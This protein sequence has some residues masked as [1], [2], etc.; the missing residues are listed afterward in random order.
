MKNIFPSIFKWFIVIAGIAITNNLLGQSQQFNTLSLK[1]GLSQGTANAIAQDL[2]GFMWMGTSD[3]LNRFDGYEFNVLRYDAQDTTSI[4]NNSITALTVGRNGDVWA[5]AEMGLNRVNPITLQANHYYHKVEN[6]KSLSSNKITA[7]AEDDLGRLWVGTDNGLNRLDNWDKNHFFRYSIESQDSVSL[8]NNKINDIFLDSKGNIW[9]ATEGG[10]NKYIVDED[11][12]K[13][14]RL[15]YNDD[16]SLSDNRVTSICEDPHGNLWVGTKNGLNK[17]NPELEV[18]S[19]YF[20]D[21]PR[22]NLLPSN[23]INDVIYDKEG[24]MWV[25]TP[26]G[27]SKV[28]KEMGK[29]TLYYTHPGKTNTLPND[30]ILCLFPGQNGM[31]WIGTRAAGVVTLDLKAPRFFSIV[32]S[33]QEGYTPEENQVYSFFEQDT[34]HIWLGTGRGVAIY[35][36]YSDKTFF[37]AKQGKKA[38]SKITYPVLSFAQTD[39]GIK[40]I[41]TDGQGLIAYNAKNDSLTYYQTNADDEF[42][43]SSNRINAIKVTADNNLWVA[44]SGGGLCFLDR[45]TNKFKIYRY[46]GRNS[47]T[48]QDNNIKTIALDKN[49]DVWFGTGNLGLYYLNVEHDEIKHYPAGDPNTGGLPS[50]GINDLFINSTNEL[51]IATAGGGLSKY[52]P[53]KDGFKTYT[54]LDGLI[55]NVVL[56]VNSDNK[57]NLWLSTNG[58]I[59]TFN[60]LTETFRNYNEQEV[61]GQNTFYARSSISTSTGLFVFGGANGFDYINANGIQENFLLPPLI[62]TSFQLINKRESH[63]N[64]NLHIDTNEEIILDF[65]HSGFAIEFAALNF[66]QSQ[67]NQYAYRLKGLFDQWRYIGTRNFATFSNL[68]PG[69]YSFEVIGSNNDGYWNDS[70]ATLKVIVQ[71]AYWQTSWFRILVLVAILGVLYLYYKFKLSSEKERNQRLEHAV[72]SRTAEIAKERDTNAILLKEVHHRVKNNLQI[73]ISLLNLQSRF[74]SDSK[75]MDVFSEIQNRVRSMSLIHE[76]MYKTKDLK[77]V[78]IQEYITDLAESLLSTYRLGQKVDLDVQVEVNRFN[79]DTL[80]PLGLIINEVI[81]NA[82]KYAFQEDKSG[83]I[84]VTITNREDGGFR[85]LIGDNGIGMPEEIAMGNVDSFGTELISALSEQLNGTIKLL[86]DEAGTVYQLDFED[87]EN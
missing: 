63:G 55:N 30:H 72:L 45:K 36:P 9:V 75:L 31:I 19:R 86:P 13:R 16:N 48:I 57:R 24:D 49:G 62:I 43:I 32:Y 37:Y 50:S 64:L 1:E 78:D 51:W 44:T 28:A 66:K 47:K 80:T 77:T 70:P 29:S 18:F 39:D 87:V 79:S 60:F 59:T 42:S 41:G 25:A 35:N 83:R 5:G 76:K 82:M 68:N 3:G 71:P 53:E 58:G 7:L 27:L 65:N 56:S 23:I 73:I 38:L 40:W 26:S 46:D 2:R 33:G 12:F 4:S 22:E 61:L 85:L 74:I 15:D 17:F 67:K 54:T 81:S 21:S 34:N 6:P 20:V 10:L 69:T 84:F 52:I 11:A 14:Y 8:L